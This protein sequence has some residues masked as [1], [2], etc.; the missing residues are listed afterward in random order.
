[1]SGR[2]DAIESNL[3]ELISKVDSYASSIYHVQDVA[4]NLQANPGPSSLSTGDTAFMIM[5]TAIVL[6]M[7][8]PGLGLYYAGM[9]SV[10]NVLACVMQS[11]SITCLVTFLFMCC[12]YSL[13]FCPPLVT[14]KSSEFIGDG[15]RLWYWG[16]GADSANQ[17]ATTIPESVYAT[18]Q[19]TFAIITAALIMGSFADRIKFSSM[20]VYI[21][22]PLNSWLI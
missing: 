13:S 10:K 5:S 4:R 2:L 18:Y 3:I 14:G 22:K 6:M 12:G 8:I 19:L 21:S 1:M 16:L 9:V 11:F 17:L 20:L 15:S 7:T